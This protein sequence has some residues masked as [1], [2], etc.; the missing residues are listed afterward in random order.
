MWISSI[1]ELGLGDAPVAVPVELRM[2]VG[3]RRSL[4]TR[5]GG[6]VGGGGHGWKGRGGRVTKC[7]LVANLT[8][9]S[10]ASAALSNSSI[11]QV[12]RIR[13]LVDAYE[14]EVK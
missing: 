12:T 10:P 4:G 13:T 2:D 1:K 6:G 3:G 5:G 9:R 7:T 11:R 14:R 8:P